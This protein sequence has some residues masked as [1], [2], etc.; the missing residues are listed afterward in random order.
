VN[1]V[2]LLLPVIAMGGWFAGASYLRASAEAEARLGETGVRELHLKVLVGRDGYRLTSG[3]GHVDD[4][5]VPCPAGDCASVHDW[6]QETLTSLLRR[7]KRAHPDENGLTLVPAHDVPYAAVLRSVD[8]CR[9][10]VNDE[11]FPFVIVAGGL[12]GTPPP[13]P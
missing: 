9:G 12:R 6:D 5:R 4:I 11:L 8:A 1:L 3:R 13:S 2:T 7:L 10:T